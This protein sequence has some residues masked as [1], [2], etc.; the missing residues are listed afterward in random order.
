M[1]LAIC[2]L[3]TLS[4]DQYQ[5]GSPVNGPPRRLIASLT[6]VRSQ[7][8]SYFR[9]FGT[10][11]VCSSTFL[12]IVYWTN[13][14]GQPSFTVQMPPLDKSSYA[15][16]NESASMPG[17]DFTAISTTRALF[18]GSYIQRWALRTAVIKS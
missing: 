1:M 2:H 17:F 14:F 18:L 10:P 12:S 11:A 4:N 6:I 13:S 15:L 8:C 9:S 5:R 16:P 3:L 7:I